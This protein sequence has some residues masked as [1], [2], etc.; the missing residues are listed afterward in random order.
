MTKIVL[1]FEPAL[2]ALCFKHRPEQPYGAND[3]QHIARY[4][5]AGGLDAGRRHVPIVDEGVR[6]AIAFVSRM[7]RYVVRFR[8]TSSPMRLPGTRRRCA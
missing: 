8:G 5:V 6:Q 4:V 1:S 7:E 3:G 2:H